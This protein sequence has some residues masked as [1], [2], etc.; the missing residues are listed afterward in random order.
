MTII[1]DKF[2]VCKLRYAKTNQTHKNTVFTILQM[3][4]N[5]QA[6]YVEKLPSGK[7]SCKGMGHTHPD[8]KATKTLNGI[9]VPVGKGVPATEA[10]TSG[11]LY[12]EYPFT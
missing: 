4:E 5:L 12:N 8:P 7:H 2:L 3:Y 11:L 1:V 6:K 9:E 10:K